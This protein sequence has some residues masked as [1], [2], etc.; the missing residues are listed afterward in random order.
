MT[1]YRQDMP[2]KGGYKPID[3]AMR[4]PRKGPSGYMMFAGFAAF[5]SVAAVGLHYNYKYLDRN[6][7]E[8]TESRI[9]VEPLLRAERDRLYL[10]RLRE[11]REAEEK[12]M[13]DDPNWKVG[14]LNG[15]PIFHNVR[16][17]WYDPPLYEYYSMVKYKDY[18][19]H[20]VEHTRH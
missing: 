13:A 6:R 11:N 12:L 5:T 1:T 20:T 19:R 3:W 4:M 9:A 18:Y 17:R 16:G 2:P 14:T 7:L 15:E 8:V 10:K